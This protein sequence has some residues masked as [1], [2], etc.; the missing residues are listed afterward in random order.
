MAY[1]QTRDWFLP[2]AYFFL[3]LT[4]MAKVIYTAAVA[5]L[6]GKLAG[7]TFQRSIGGAQLRTGTSPRNPNTSQ[8]QFIR[9]NMHSLAASWRALSVDARSSWGFAARTP[10]LGFSLYIQRNQQLVLAG[11]PPIPSFV[12]P[13]PPLVLTQVVLSGPGIPFNVQIEVNLPA[14]PPGYTQIN[15][16]SKWLPPGVT[17]TSTLQNV[18]NV[19]NFAWDADA[20]GYNFDPAAE[21]FPPGS[22]WSARMAY[23]AIENASGLI[24]LSTFL[25][26]VNP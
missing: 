10:S 25:D 15:R 24:S 13:N 16:W 22:G 4:V 1:Q 21:D 18:L 7:S 3:N 14:A 11:L 8:Q 19:A 6:S 12:L 9:V 26:F 23:G 2:V 20:S 5:S 17:F